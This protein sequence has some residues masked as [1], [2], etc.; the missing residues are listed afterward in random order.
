M[1]SLEKQDI[2]VLLRKI[3][4]T[5]K[6]RIE[7]SERLN[8]KDEIFQILSVFYSIIIV[9]LSI[10]NIQIQ[11][12]SLQKKSSFVILSTSIALSLFAMFI[13]S[14]NYK[15][16]Y[17][18]LKINYIELDN[19]YSELKN[20]TKVESVE[21]TK[22]M[23]IN[24]KYNDLLKYVENH[25]TYDYLKV[26]NCSKEEKIKLSKEQ[27][28]SLYRY[29]FIEIFLNIMFFICPPIIILL[30]IKIF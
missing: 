8:K 3:W 24:K 2:E 23:E 12:Y 22:F 5:K 25:S 9:A 11:D 10:W 14:R 6:S 17:F 1:V 15:E 30:L 18:N 21:I 20:I 27:I 13:T 28:T 29:K 16:R 4:I 19:L 26:M 7:A